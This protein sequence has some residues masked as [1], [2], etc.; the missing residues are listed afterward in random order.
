MADKMHLLVMCSWSH[1]DPLVWRYVLPYLPLIKKALPPAVEIHLQTF[2]SNNKTINPTFEE[3]LRSM[4]VRWLALPYTPLKA[5]GW[6]HYVQNLWTV[7]AYCNKNAIKT[8]HAFA[9]VA[10]TMAYLAARF[11]R[12]QLVI[13]SWEPHAECMVDTGVWSPSS[14]AFKI[15]F[16]FEKQQAKSAQYLIAAHPRMRDYAW[17]KW[18][19][20]PK[21]IAYRPACTDLSVFD[22]SL[23]NRMFIREKLGISDQDIVCACVS[24]LGGLYYFDE[25]LLFFKQAH[26]H[27]GDRFKVILL[28]STP[29]VDIL[30]QA[31]ALHFD[32]AALTILQAPPEDV[33]A[34]LA[35]ADF[36]FNPQ[37]GVPSKA[38]GTPVKNGEY[39][40]M[41]LPIAMLAG[42]SQDASLAISNATGVVLSDMTP[43]CIQDA[44][45]A[46]ENL[47]SDNQLRA[48]CRSMSI[49]YRNFDLAVKAYEE[50]YGGK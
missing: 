17:A 21:H 4:N 49:Q 47:L 37:K 39:W 25:A 6:W 45:Q 1:R 32:N 15:L 31:S 19:I 10:G 20:A 30:K 24:Q 18:Q 7:R 48:R 13:D 23:Y 26:T 16:Y 35:A 38:F 12:R 43:Q 40:A 41:G 8:L 42:T 3:T 50:V 28:T 46:L 22:P 14:M 34:Y 9:P 5:G 2:E 27:F 33:P 29:A 36:A 44:L 11:S